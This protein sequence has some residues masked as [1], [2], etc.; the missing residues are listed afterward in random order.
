MPDLD[1]FLDRELAKRDGRPC[2]MCDES[3]CEA[4]EGYGVVTE[5]K[6]RE[7]TE[8]HHADHYDYREAREHA[9]LADGY[10]R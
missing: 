4:C 6:W 5:L 8:E 9:L 7:L 3:G 2:P 1:A 10:W